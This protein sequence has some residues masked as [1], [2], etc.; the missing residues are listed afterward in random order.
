MLAALH[1][2]RRHARRH[3]L[4]HFP[5]LSLSHKSHTIPA[6]RAT[7]RGSCL[8]GICHL[9]LS[10][11]ILSYHANSFSRADDR[12]HP[13]SCC[14]IL[15]RYPIRLPEHATGGCTRFRFHACPSDI[16]YASGDFTV[17]TTPPLFSASIASSH[18]GRL[19][20]VERWCCACPINRHSLKIS[21][22][23]RCFQEIWLLLPFLNSV[24]CDKRNRQK[25]GQQ[26][27]RMV[28]SQ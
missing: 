5:S 21:L 12:L 19:V 10:N 22:S 27:A 7:Q 25:N 20:P 15:L 4:S 14:V 17:R 24:S 28:L 3:G 26:S 6:K 1:M 16:R 8:C 2:I 11:C 13:F 23:Y 18:G 9:F